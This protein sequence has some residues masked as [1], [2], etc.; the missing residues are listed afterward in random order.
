MLVASIGLG[1]DAVAFGSDLG[2]DPAALAVALAAGSSGG[3]WT[4]FVS[5]APERPRDR[6][7][8]EWARK[9]VGFAMQLANEV[10]LELDREILRLARRGVEVVG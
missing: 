6:P 7:G 8:T 2:L 9:D 1:E 4:R 5:A 10:G 3:T